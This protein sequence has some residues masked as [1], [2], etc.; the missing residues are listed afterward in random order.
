MVQN[1]YRSH[2]DLEEAFLKIIESSPW[3]ASRFISKLTGIPPRKVY[4]YLKMR[5]IILKPQ[6]VLNFHCGCLAP[7]NNL[8]EALEHVSKTYHRVTL[9]GSLRLAEFMSVK[10]IDSALIDNLVLSF[11]C[12][13]GFIGDSY[14]RAVHHINTQPTHKIDVFGKIAPT[15]NVGAS[16]GQPYQI[17]WS[18]RCP[19]PYGVVESER[20]ISSKKKEVNI[21]CLRK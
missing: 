21:V 10:E 18:R 7:I 5:R 20:V 8:N 9:R 1:K 2:S 17:K 14:A 12:G 15:S 4:H 16:A 13:C 6:L 11:R 3:R 19:N